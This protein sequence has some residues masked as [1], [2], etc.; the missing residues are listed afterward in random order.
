MHGDQPR[1]PGGPSDVPQDG[2]GGGGEL[3]ALPRPDEIAGRAGADRRAEGRD[4]FAG[5]EREDG[6]RGRARVEQPRLRHDHV[7]LELP[8][9]LGELAIVGGGG[10]DA[11]PPAAIEE[12][13]HLLDDL[14]R[15]EREHDPGDLVHDPPPMMRDPSRRRTT[16]HA[17][18]RRRHAAT[19]YRG[20]DRRTASVTAGSTRA[21]TRSNG[22]SIAPVASVKTVSP[23]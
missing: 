7:G 9:R 18:R 23:S 21:A 17:T 16:T 8:N 1:P 11:R 3:L 19:I 22:P 12:V 14:R 10:D 13:H 6:T 5:I 4:R 2:R 20:T 15:L